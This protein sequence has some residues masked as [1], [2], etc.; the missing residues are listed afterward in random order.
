[1]A[2]RR[3]KKGDKVKYADWTETM[4]VVDVHMDGGWGLTY[5]LSCPDPTM[6]SPD[7]VRLVFAKA[8]NVRAA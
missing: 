2:Y 6:D 3:F 5:E 1:M 8:R 4:E 7:R